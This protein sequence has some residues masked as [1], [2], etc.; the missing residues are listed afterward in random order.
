MNNQRERVDLY[1]KLYFAYRVLASAITTG[2]QV[3][4]AEAKYYIKALEAKL[5]L[6]R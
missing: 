4:E 3:S 5:A 2:D 6:L 1:L